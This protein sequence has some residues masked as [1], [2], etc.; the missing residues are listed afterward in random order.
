MSKKI[1][2]VPVKYLEDTDEMFLEF[3]PEVMDSMGWKVGDTLKWVI[4]E[5][6][7]L[8]INKPKYEN[9]ELEFTEKELFKYMLMAHELDITFNEF[10][11]QALQHV[12]DNH[13]GD[14]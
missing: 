12:I 3:P 2:T 5:D 8:L 4:D 1:R 9:V 10:V 11:Q 14:E 6:G 7:N 13:V